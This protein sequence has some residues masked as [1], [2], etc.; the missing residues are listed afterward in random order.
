MSNFLETDSIVPVQKKNDD[1][2][3][4]NCVD[5]FTIRRKYFYPNNVKLNIKKI[6]VKR[7]IQLKKKDEKNIKISDD[8]DKCQIF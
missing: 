5:D 4:I 8:S 3:I 6:N 7:I 2:F 1:N